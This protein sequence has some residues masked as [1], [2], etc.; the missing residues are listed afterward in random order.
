[1]KSKYPHANQLRLLFT[2][3][4]SLAYA[5]RTENI[6][7]DMAVDAAARYDFSE[8]PRDHPLY[9]ERNHKSIGYFKDE[10]HSIPME[11]F[12]DLWPKCYAFRHTGKIKNNVLKHSDSVKKKTAMGVKRKI[13][14]D[15]LHFQHYL[16]AFKN[17]HSFVVKQNLLSSTKH[18]AYCLQNWFNSLRHEEMA[19]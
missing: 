9:N 11:E 5:V 6:Y 1:M 12:V 8:Y 4:G 13:M 19:V 7:A 10:L 16:D 2:D 17:F 14:E 15:H 3:T 18:Q